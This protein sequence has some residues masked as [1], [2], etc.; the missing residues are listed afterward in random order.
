[1]DLIIRQD[2]TSQ[3][4]L[5]MR[6]LRFSIAGLMGIVLVAAIGLA[7]LRSPS[8]IWAGAIFSLTCAV[9]GLAIVGAIYCKGAARAWWLGFCVFGWGYLA[10]VGFSRAGPPFAQLPTTQLL[11]A[12]GPVLGHPAEVFTVPRAPN[13][14]RFL[15]NYFQIG[16]ALLALLAGLAGGTLARLFLAL[17]VDR[18]EA[19]DSETSATVPDPPKPKRWLRPVLI[20]WTALVLACAVAAIRSGSDAAAAW[21]GVTFFLTCGL[22]GLACLSAIF[23]RGRRRQSGV[24]AALFGVGYLLLA[25]ARAPYQLLPP[26]QVMSARSLYQPLPTSSFLN[27]L[28]RWTIAAAGGNVSADARIIAALEQPVAMTFPQPTPLQDVLRY[29]TMATATPDHPGIPIYLDP[30]ALLEADM[31]PTSTVTIDLIGVPLKTSLRLS[32]NQLGL[33]YIVQGGCLRVTIEPDPA[34][35]EGPYLVAYHPR[36]K[37][38][39]A[40]AELTSDLDDPFLVVGHCL[41][42]LIAAGFGA[43]AAPLVTG[44]PREPA[45]QRPGPLGDARPAESTPE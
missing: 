43:L 26:G 32:L 36:W 23:G 38:S 37:T 39:D 14:W 7:A 25:F 29:V 11:L 10:M 35:L 9:L 19:P 1:M 21:A 33:D 34:E 17:P 41:L 28:R 6:R 4:T 42:T 15:N 27:G 22:L 44:P 16:H 13:G 45:G 8:A 18:S 30:I 5:I 12:L 2:L 31:T 24:G 40:M 20:A 3:R